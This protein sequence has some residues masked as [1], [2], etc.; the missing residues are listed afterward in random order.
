MALITQMSTWPREMSENSSV[1]EFLNFR[2]FYNTKF[3]FIISLAFDSLCVKSVIACS[4][5]QNATC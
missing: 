2:E 5:W 1:T 4:K 3:I